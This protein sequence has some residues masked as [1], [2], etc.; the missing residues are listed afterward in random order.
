MSALP[1]KADIGQ[2]LL[3]QSWRGKVDTLDAQDRQNQQ[4]DYPERTG[5]FAQTERY[6]AQFGALAALRDP[7]PPASSLRWGFGGDGDGR[8][9]TEGDPDDQ[10][11]GEAQTRITRKQQQDQ[12]P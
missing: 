6:C 3:L 4:Q 9:I 2:R 8:R 1:P 12:D 7:A 10:G 11:K 5:L